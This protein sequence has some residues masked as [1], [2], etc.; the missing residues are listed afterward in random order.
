[1]RVNFTEPTPITSP[2]SQHSTRPF[3]EYDF[4]VSNVRV[5]APDKQEPEDDEAVFDIH[6]G[7]SVVYVA[8]KVEAKRCH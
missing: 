4:E 1:M 3:F 7:S 5:V 2:V 8:V 6:V